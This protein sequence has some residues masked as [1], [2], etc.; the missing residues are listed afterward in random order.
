MPPARIG[1]APSAETAAIARMA[2]KHHYLA[3]VSTIIEE[4]SGRCR[5]LEAI[6]GM[7]VNT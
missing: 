5:G 7:S 1:I 4:A 2:F 6:W 3:N